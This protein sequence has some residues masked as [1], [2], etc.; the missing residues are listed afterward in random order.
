MPADVVALRL[1]FVLVVYVLVAV[2]GDKG[3]M[4]VRGEMGD[5]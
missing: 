3:G 4:G 2:V 1:L 5:V